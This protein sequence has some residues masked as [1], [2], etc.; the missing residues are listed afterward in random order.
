MRIDLRH[1][2]KILDLGLGDLECGAFYV[3][4]KTD[5]RGTLGVCLL[6][7]QDRKVLGSLLGPD[8]NKYLDNKTVKVLSVFHPFCGCQ[9]LAKALFLSYLY[10]IYGIIKSLELCFTLGPNKGNLVPSGMSQMSSFCSHL[11]PKNRAFF[12]CSCLLSSSNTSQIKA[13]AFGAQR[14]SRSQEHF[15]FFFQEHFNGR[16]RTLGQGGNLKDFLGSLG[17][18]CSGKPCWC[19]ICTQ[20]EEHSCHG[21]VPSSL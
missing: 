21:K 20:E 11:H 14:K 9:P 19:C 17:T 5:I 3:R 1:E 4:V 15:L 8:Y 2:G 16:E 13:L 10:I 12:L 18:V 7:T 6:R